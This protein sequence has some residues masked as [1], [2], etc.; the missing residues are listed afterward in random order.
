[1]RGA[2]LAVLLTT[3]FASAFPTLR[4]HRTY[5]KTPTHPDA[6]VI[7]ALV[8]LEA[9]VNSKYRVNYRF[10][11]F[12]SVSDED[13]YDET[14]NFRV[15][16]CMAN[17]LGAVAPRPFPI[18]KAGR[19]WALDITEP[20]WSAEAFHEVAKLEQTCREPNIQH[21]LAETLRG[22]IGVTADV[23]TFHCEGLIPA[24]WFV[25]QLQETDLQRER[26]EDI[27]YYNLLYSRERF[28]EANGHEP[29]KPKERPWKGGVFPGDGKDYPAGS[30]QFIPKIELDAY[31]KAS[32]AWKSNKR[33]GF[34][35]RNFPR[36]ADDF[37]ERWGGRASLD[38]LAKQRVFKKNGAVIAGAF[39]DPKNG[40]YVS[41]NDRINEFLLTPFGIGMDTQDFDRTSGRKNPANLPLEVAL[42]QLEEDASEKI[43]QKQDD[44]PAFLL[45]GPRKQGRKRVESGD[46][47]I[48]HD[49]INGGTM[50]VQSI[51]KCIGCH[52]PSDVVLAPSND[53]I[54][55]SI[56]RRNDL[57]S[58]SK[59]EQQVIEAFFFDGVAARGGWQRKIK[60]WR[61]P[62]AFSL[63]GATITM[64]EKDGWIGTRFAAT[65]NG[66]RDM[67]EFPV[68]LE[69]AA[70]EL[71]YSRLAVV[72]ACAQ[73]TDPDTQALVRGI[74][75]LKA[76]NA[77]D[78]GTL[79][80]DTEPGVP[81]AA[82]DD[83]LFPQLALVLA[84]ARDAE[85]PAPWLLMLEPDLVRDKNARLYEPKGDKK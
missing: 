37:Q 64:R 25:R 54:G 38:F 75:H 84:L 80:L 14:Q 36:D 67:Y 16:V 2:L 28:G 42:D 82:W 11:H 66:R 53:K 59:Q 63:A 20:G 47:H 13:L 29:I 32:A 27:V 61:E 5:V 6:A 41:D 26:P 7:E 22:M 3:S 60:A 18:D 46:P 57:L 24:P 68:L 77:F 8:F 33:V 49:R 56:R 81:R 9:K 45:T 10:F 72:A 85:D 48:V 17:G 58:Y 12:L 43:Y 21:Q 40:S 69:Q 71:G 65:S 51:H 78:A 70:A 79:L 83:E 76:T 30:F 62:F 55:E 34:I 52:Y 73:L 19:V 44:F 15:Y 35:D 39:N 4:P 1:M 31:D 23:R 74:L 50:I